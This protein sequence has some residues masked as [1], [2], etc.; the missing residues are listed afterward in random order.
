MYGRLYYSPNLYSSGSSQMM[1]CVDLK[2]GAFQWEVNTTAA[3]GT[4]LWSSGYTTTLVGQPFGYYYSQDDINEH[5]IQNPGWLFSA[6]FT[7]GFQ[8]QRGIAY[9]HI[10]NYP[11]TGNNT[12]ATTYAINGPAGEVL[13]FAFQ[14]KGNTTNPSYYLNQ[15][16]SSRTVPS[17]TAGADPSSATIDASTASRY[18]WNV[19]SP[20]KFTTAPTIRA[21]SLD[22]QIL[23]GSNGSW[24]TGSGAPSYA[25]PDNVSIWAISLNP[26]TLGQLL[27]MSNFQTDDPV[28]NTNNIL[29]H[30]DADVGTDGVFVTEV[31]PTQQFVCYD[32]RTGSLLWSGDIQSQTLTPYGYYTWAS[33]AGTT[34]T[35]IAY[36]MLYTGGYTGTLTAYNLTNGAIVW[37]DN[38]IPP[39]TAG[40][41]KS[42][43][44]MLGLIADGMIYVGSHEHSAETPLESGN[45]VRC[46]NATTG[47]TIWQMSGWAFPMTF[48]VAD[49]V[50]VYWNDYDGQIYAVGQGPTQTVV[51]APQA[52]IELGHSLVIS[53]TVMDTSAGMQQPTVKTDFPNG[54][55]A[56]SEDSMGQW[57]EY[58]YMQKVKP[59]NTTGVPV[60]IDAVDSNNN[61]RHI[62]DTTTDSSGVFSF[63]YTPDIVGKYTVTATFAGSNSYYGSSSETNFAVDPAHP[64]ASPVPTQAPGAADQFFVPAIAG[65]F[66]LVIV[67]AIVLA[68]LMLRKRP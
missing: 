63:Q 35:K 15:W 31:L 57:M 6:S 40:N 67:V 17:V 68:L 27:Y 65:L 45:L 60:S 12:A 20:I 30:S 19:S 37:R 47:E 66:V 4:T 29:V 54:V 7:V 32:M 58:V 36:G 28:A 49:G 9:I 61:V 64:T 5:G 39:G 42:T 51:S 10:A 38:I 16:N 34:Q 43:P 18:D 46:L 24:P 44:S 2:T 55:P 33:L 59:S 8:A 22:N 41:L 25:Y 56:V 23:W 48:A 52:S 3:A 53:G 11:G 26:T 21:A 50:L 14:N 1:D 13:C 62:G